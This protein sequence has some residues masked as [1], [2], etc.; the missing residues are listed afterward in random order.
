MSGSNAVRTL[1][2]LRLTRILELLVLLGYGFWTLL[3][4][5]HSW[6]VAWPL[7]AIWQLSVL[8]PVA[9]LLLAKWM[10]PRWRWD[11]L[12]IDAIVFLGLIWCA[13]SASVA[14]FSPQA[15]LNASAVF[16][17]VAAFYA[18]RQR[19]TVSGAQRLLT[20]QGGLTV[21][22][23]GI[24]LLLWGWQTYLPELERWR[25]LRSQ[26]I[27]SAFHLS[28]L[29]L[30]NWHPIGHQNYVAGFLILN[31]PLLIGLAL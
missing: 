9:W 12:G 16:G 22:F 8:L 26:Q 17:V 29:A 11:G 14:E 3:P 5:S 20:Y 15:W 21:S 13:V 24:S 31:I 25:W 1:L 4:N 2:P 28:D 30:R 10:T 7:S 19:L 18:L 23:A 6:M 27:D